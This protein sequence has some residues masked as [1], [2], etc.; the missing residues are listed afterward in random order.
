MTEG[1]TCQ[2]DGLDNGDKD[3]GGSQLHEAVAQLCDALGQQVV[4]VICVLRTS[5]QRLTT[6]RNSTPALSSH[7]TCE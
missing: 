6:I 1:Q 5:K 7:A 3:E 4:H 2:E